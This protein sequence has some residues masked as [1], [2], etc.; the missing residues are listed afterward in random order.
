MDVVV[1]ECSDDFCS[2]GGALRRT[3]SATDVWH[4]HDPVITWL[5]ESKLKW[6][7]VVLVNSRRNKGRENE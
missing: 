5:F 1:Q 4:V 2:L 6:S 7:R 3:E